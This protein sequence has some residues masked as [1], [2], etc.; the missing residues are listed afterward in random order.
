MAQYN[1]QPSNIPDDMFAPLEQAE[2][3]E[4][5]QTKSDSYWRESFRRLLENRM[6][7]IG[8]IFILILTFMAIVGPM[9]N[10]HTYRSQSIIQSNQPPSS[11]YW[12]GTDEL[13]RDMFTRT[14]YGARVSLFV[15][16]AA[17]TIEFVIGVVYGSVSGYKG[18][19]IDEVLMRIVDVL[20]GL[21]YILLV[22][23]LMVFMGPGL[24]TIIVALSVTGWIGMARLVR[25]QVLQLKANEYVLAAR[26][27]GAKTSHIIRKH[28][29]PNTSGPIIV[30]MTLAIPNAIFAEAFLSF[31]GLGVQAPVAS[32]GTMANDALSAIQT[33]YWW[34]LFFPAFFISLTM[35]AFNVFG[36]GL[37]DALDPRM[38]R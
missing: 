18:G 10:E 4:I 6:A 27:M 21:P 11:E 12:F 31:L 14:W 5:Q 25:G 30:S 8:L 7:A 13:G 24:F 16:I 9:L 35:F 23:L 37:R 29:I 17:A 1:Q 15:G 36:D 38:R 33:G 26:A 2:K 22:I 34:R 20:Y 19:R 3:K 28:I 32:W